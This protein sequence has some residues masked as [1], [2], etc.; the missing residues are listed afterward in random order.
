M[1]RKPQTWFGTANGHKATD[2]AGAANGQK[3]I[4]RTGSANGPG[5]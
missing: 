3:A 4:G 2:M 5:V 1:V